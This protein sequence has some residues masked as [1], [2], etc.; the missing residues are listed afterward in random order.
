MGYRPIFLIRVADVT[1]AIM[2][3]VGAYEKFEGEKFSEWLTDQPDAELQKFGLIY[4]HGHSS[5]MTAWIEG[6]LE[7]CGIDYAKFGDF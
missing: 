2:K 7:L 5:A 1:P 6:G 4:M 3:T